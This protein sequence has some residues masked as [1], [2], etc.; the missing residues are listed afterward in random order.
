MDLED[1]VEMK[2]VAHFGQ[3]DDMNKYV[4]DA[5]DATH[6]STDW[7]DASLQQ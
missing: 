2:K 4:K 3:V 6:G 7:A 1:G 5:K